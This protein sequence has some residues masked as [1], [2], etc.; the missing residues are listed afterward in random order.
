M[1]TTLP[2]FI[3][4]SFY[5]LAMLGLGWLGYRATYNLSDYI[6]G[7]RRLNSFVVA[8]A[9]GASDMSGWL[10]MALPGALY[11]TGI[12]GAWSAVGLAIGAWTNW[13]FVAARLRVYT[14]K[15][16][17]ALTLPE[18]FSNR[19][20]D[21]SNILR[22]FTASAILIF[23]S[24]YCASGIVASA[25]LFENMLGMPY[26]TALW[27]GAFM[28]ISYVFF[29]GFLAV[30]WTDTVQA[31]LMFAALIVTPLLVIHSHSS[32]ATSIDAV[33]I[34]GADHV[35]LTGSL[36][37]IGVISLL[38][39][40]LGYFGQPHILARFMAAKSPKHLPTARRISMTWMI[41]CL[42]GASSIGFFGSSYFAMHPGLAA[43]VKANPETIFIE[44][45]KILFNPWIGGIILAGILSAVMSTLSAQLL[46]C[47]SALTEDVYRTFIRRKAPQKELVWVGRFMVLG[48]ALFAIWLASNPDSR[49]LKMVSYAWAGFAAAFGPVVVLSIFWSRMTRSGALAGIVVGTL[50]V[51]I[52]GKYAW[53]GLYEILPGCVFA[54]I[55]IVV[56]SLLSQAPSASMLKMF[57]EVEDEV[58][59]F[60]KQDD[61]DDDLVP[62]S[63]GSTVT[64]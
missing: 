12:A 50:T 62:V 33:K 55:A 40:G 10:M 44:L 3:A 30:S 61:E 39:W 5:L 42:I 52:W 2:T 47:S 56:V 13:R 16:G 26:D 54:A 59:S 57:K 36:S 53:F 7:G 19:F 34:I 35:T 9:A 37:A 15:C 11:A 27:V 17:N 28:T 64:E 29:G 25:R 49:V 23:F 21:H 4:F 38:C 31:A 46:V 63:V 60:D 24:V 58:R 22:I 18:Y 45:T 14:E 20:E 8:L 43:A 48:I 6:L 51:A 1:T 32:M 41:L